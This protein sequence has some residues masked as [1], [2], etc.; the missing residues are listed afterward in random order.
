MKDFKGAVLR[1]AERALE[2]TGLGWGLAWVAVPLGI[3]VNPALLAHYG[4]VGGLA[5]GAVE[6]AADRDFAMAATR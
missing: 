5:F 2:G 4:L 1:T 6:S 3:A